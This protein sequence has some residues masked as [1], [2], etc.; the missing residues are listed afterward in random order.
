MKK[1]LNRIPLLDLN[2]SAFQ[3]LHGNTPELELQGTRVIFLFNPDDTFYKLSALYNQNTPV[4]CL[5]FVQ[6]QREI[7]A[8]MLAKKGGQK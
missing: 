6:A 2:I 5:D 1:T 4:N 8:M 3:H 7:R